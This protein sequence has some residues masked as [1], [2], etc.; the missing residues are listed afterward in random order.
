MIITGPTTTPSISNL[1]PASKRIPG[2]GSVSAASTRIR[3]PLATGFP[4]CRL[5]LRT[6]ALRLAARQFVKSFATSDVV[7]A[8]PIVHDYARKKASGE[9]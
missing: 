8:S 2:N 4:E 1:N 6:A 9:P 3:R 7:A 5:P